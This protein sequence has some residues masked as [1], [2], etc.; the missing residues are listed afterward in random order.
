MAEPTTELRQWLRKADDDLRAGRAVLALTPPLVEVALF[1][2]QQAA[3]KAAKGFLVSKDAEV[4]RSH[5]LGA[6]AQLVLDLDPS[7]EPLLVRIA[8]LTPFAVTFRYPG[9]YGKPTRDE[10][11]TALDDAEAL[12]RAMRARV[13]L[14]LE[15][16]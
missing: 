16:Q 1:H 4:P 11:Q 2:A 10:A 14:V 15:P 7:L 12:L 5:D 13:E 8:P 9:Y 3:E 6:I